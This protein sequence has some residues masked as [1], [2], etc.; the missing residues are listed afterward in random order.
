MPTF[1]FSDSQAKTIKGWIEDKIQVLFDDPY[2]V[3][4][5]EEGT[6]LEYVLHLKSICEAVGMD[7]TQVARK[8]STNFERRRMIKII[9]NCKFLPSED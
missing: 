9:P 4:D 8:Q 3:L 2:G 6:E 7:F 1:T 5:S